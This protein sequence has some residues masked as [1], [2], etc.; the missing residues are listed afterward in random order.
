MKLVLDNCSSISNVFEKYTSSG[1]FAI[2][3]ILLLLLL[4]KEETTFYENHFL[5]SF[6]YL[7]FY[8]FLFDHLWAK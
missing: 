1:K 3:R 5:K 6:Y 2:L 8:Y 4:L 7:L